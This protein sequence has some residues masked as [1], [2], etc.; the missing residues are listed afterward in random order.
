MCKVAM[1][2]PQQEIRNTMADIFMTLVQ[3]VI[4]H[5]KQRKR[6]SE[7]ISNFLNITLIIY[8]LR[9]HRFSWFLV[10]ISGSH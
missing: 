1:K 2:Q 8:V 7:G 9:F 6:E 10:S 4:F 3:E 5:V